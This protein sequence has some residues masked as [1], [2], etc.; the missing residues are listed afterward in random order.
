MTPREFIDRLTPGA[1]ECE[2]RLHIPAAFTIAQAALESGWGESKLTRDANNLFGIKAHHGWPGETY[3]IATAEYVD[4]NRVMETAAFRKYSSWEASLLDHGKFLRDNPR[5]AACFA[6]TT[7]EGWARAVAK[8]GYATDPQYASKIVTIIRQHQ[9][10]AIRAGEPAPAPIEESKP[11]WTA[12]KPAG[13]EPPMAAPIFTML[14]PSLISAIPELAKVFGSGSEVATR[15]VKA[16]EIVAEMAKSVT[17][18]VNEQQAVERIV[19][20]P[21]VRDTFRTAVQDRYWE[22]SES[23]SGGIGAARAAD[24]ARVA[25]GKPIW[26]S[27]TWVMGVLLLPLVYMIAYSVTFQGDSWDAGVRASLATG[28]VSLVLGGV[29]G[30]YFGASRNAGGMR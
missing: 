13:K 26:Q 11:S 27:A 30:Y 20:D 5:Y 22:L 9:L 14:L 19:T 2:R 1:L 7:P 25:T 18:A 16:V 4:G 24:E 23:G 3:E 10:D 12:P 21:A 6:E 8:A 15:N 29:A 17:G 28:I